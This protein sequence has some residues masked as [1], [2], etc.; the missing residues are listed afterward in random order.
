MKCAHLSDMLRQAK[1][2]TENQL[3]DFSDFSWRYCSDTGRSKGAY[4]I[5]YRGGIIDHVTYVLGQF[6]QSST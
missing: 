1:I 4:I 5:F 2:K 6:V 3:V